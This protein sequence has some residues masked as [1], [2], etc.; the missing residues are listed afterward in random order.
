MA[1]KFIFQRGNYAFGAAQCV[2]TQISDSNKAKRKTGNA[3]K[4]TRF[5]YI[6]RF[7]TVRMPHLFEGKQKQ[8]LAHSQRAAQ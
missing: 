1:E 3:G 2:L 5:A 8:L 7:S 6:N 4:H